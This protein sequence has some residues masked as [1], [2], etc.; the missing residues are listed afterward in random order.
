MDAK[1]KEEIIKR[2]MI[3]IIENVIKG[4]EEKAMCPF[5]DT[6]IVYEYHPSV[7]VYKCQ[8]GNCFYKAYRGI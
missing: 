5:C 2:T 1:E 4:I 6:D 7:A 8:T 3:R